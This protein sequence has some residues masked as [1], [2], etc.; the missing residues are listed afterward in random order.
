MKHLSIVG[1]FKYPPGTIPGKTTDS[2]GTL[3]DLNKLDEQDD[4]RKMSFEVHNRIKNIVGELEDIRVTIV[5]VSHS[6]FTM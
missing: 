3:N 1:V 5:S 6:I 2:Y 4:L